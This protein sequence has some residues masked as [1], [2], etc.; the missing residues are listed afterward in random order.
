MSKT[1]GVAAVANGSLILNAG[2]TLLLGAANQIGDA[3]PMTLTGGTFQTAGFSEQLGTLKLTANSVID[4]GAGASV[5][6][7]AASSGVAWTAAT[8]L[9][10]TN[11]NGSIKGGGADQLIF[12]ANSSALTAGQVS[13]VWFANPAGFPAGTYAA[14]ILSTGE[15]VPLAAAPGNH[16]PAGQSD[17]GCGEHCVLYRGGAPARPRPP[18]SGVSTAPICP[19]ATALRWLLTSVDDQ[20]GG[21]LLRQRHQP[22]RLD[23]QHHGCS[24]GL[25]YGGALT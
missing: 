14:A 18:T 17:G 7:F 3:V 6:K 22:G 23:Q 10:I 13:Q 24:I 1:A 4:L 2:G 5:L 9:T 15:V 8:T 11:W 20:P 16:A 12:G 25:C 21:Q 19:A